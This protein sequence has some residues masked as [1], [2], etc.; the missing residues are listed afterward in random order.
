M[1][2]KKI[3]I[4]IGGDMMADLRKQSKSPDRSLMG[5]RTIYLKDMNQFARIFSPERLNLLWQLVHVTERLTMDELA[6]RVGRKQEAVSRDISILEKE[7]LIRKEKEKQRV[8]PRAT[9][10][11]ILIQFTKPVSV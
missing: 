2:Y 6:A 9:F 7:E 5:T 3:I 4:K 10:K 11:E 8:Y 1:S